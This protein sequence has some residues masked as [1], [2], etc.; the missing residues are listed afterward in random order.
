MRPTPGP[1]V[2]AHSSRDGCR[3]CRPCRGA[4]GPV[5]HFA[6]VARVQD[7][8]QG[9]G[10]RE[11]RHRHR[12]QA[13]YRRRFQSDGPNDGGTIGMAAGHVRF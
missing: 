11:G 4:A 12:W 1:G 8:G 2:A 10:G 7:A 5:R 3:P 6:A 9:G 13:G